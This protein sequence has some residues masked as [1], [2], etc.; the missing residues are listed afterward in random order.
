MYRQSRDRV[1]GAL[2]AS[3][4]PYSSSYED[5][6]DYYGD[7]EK[8]RESISAG[9]TSVGPLS[10]RKVHCGEKRHVGGL[11]HAPSCRLVCR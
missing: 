7:I 4:P 1:T 8:N 3:T 11:I 9:W 2:P 5:E 6:E 10:R